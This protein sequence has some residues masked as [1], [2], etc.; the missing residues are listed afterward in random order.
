MSE[1]S[2]QT[3]ANPAPILPPTPPQRR[4]ERFHYARQVLRALASLRLTVFLF[5]LS[6]ILVFC[7]TLAMMD[8]GLPTVLRQYF[9]SGIAWIPLQLFVRLGQ[10]FFGVPPDTQVAGSFP[11]P[12]GW[13][14]GGVLLVNLLAAHLIRFRFTWKRSGI[15]VLHTGIVLLMVGELITGLYAVEGNMTIPLGGSS[16]YVESFDRLELAFV[17][18]KD[19]DNDN[20]TVIPTSLLQKG[21][22]IHDEELPVDV[23]VVRY[24][25]NSTLPREMPSG[26][27][28]P[29]TKGF[30]LETAAVE[31]PPG[32]GVDA[33][34]KR[35]MPSA[36]VTFK[37]KKTGASLGTYLL[38]TWQV[39][40]DVDIDGTTYQVALRFQRLYRPFTFH[41]QELRH[42]NYKGTSLAKRYASLVRVTDPSR[43]EDREV[44]IHM[45]H[46]LYYQG[47]SFY[48]SSVN[49][50]REGGEIT[51][52]QV[53]KNPG[54]VLPYIACTMVALGMAIH[55]LLH[56]LDFL[57]RKV[58]T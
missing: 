16:N 20:V 5:V 1:T 45:N 24:F 9:R 2:I 40:Q 14:I 11:F 34:Q 27:E 38:S 39:P 26:V 35:D 21:G 19:K 32:R 58:T 31:Q 43:G 46:P 12:G 7:G 6:M 22:V 4:P 48:Q 36:Y 18:P 51:G 56:L 13:L 30:G 25:A 3:R 55:F 42:E 49:S 52:L 44:L 54:W 33:E 23:E 53:V 8:Q 17:W 47:E 50:T 41:L 28:N 57:H 29:A 10:V 37:D 15:L